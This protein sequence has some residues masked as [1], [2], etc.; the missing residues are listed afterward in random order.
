MQELKGILPPLLHK[1]AEGD[2]RGPGCAGQLGRRQPLSLRSGSRPCLCSEAAPVRFSNCRTVAKSLP[3][4]EEF[5]EQHSRSFSGCFETLLCLYFNLALAG[6]LAATGLSPAIRGKHM[7]QGT[8]SLAAACNSV[9]HGVCWA[10]THCK[11]RAFR[12][13]WDR[14]AILHAGPALGCQMLEISPLSPQLH[15]APF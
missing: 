12:A 11:E 8:A 7:C 5:P 13:D 10:P 6:W 1:A 3:M 4:P 15:E 2:P 14:S 9:A